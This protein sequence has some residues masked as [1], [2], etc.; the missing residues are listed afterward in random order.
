MYYGK[1]I[2]ELELPQ[3]A[4]LAGLPKAPSAFN[5]IRNPS[6]ALERRNWILGRMNALGHIDKAAYSAAVDTPISATYHGSKTA[7]DAP[8]IA[9]MVR[10][11]MLQRFNKDIYTAGY[12]V[13]T[14]INSKLQQSAE[15]SVIKGLLAYDRRHGYRGPERQIPPAN[16]SEQTDP[17]TTPIISDE[18][19]E[20]WLAALRLKKTSGGLFPAVV[21]SVTDRAFTAIFYDG[22]EITV[23]WEAGIQ[24]LRRFI[25]IDQLSPSPKAA[26]ELVSVGDIIRVV[27]TEKGLWKLSQLPAA[28]AA[29]VSLNADDG[30]ILSLVG[31]FSYQQSKFN[32]VTQATRQPGSNFKPF[33]YTAALANGFTAA[34]T[35]NDAPIVFDDAR[36]EGAW[37]PTNDSRQ[38]LWP[39][40]LALRSLQITKP[41]VHTATSFPRNS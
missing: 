30:G 10:K 24:G 39:N 20:Q 23:E 36:L 2:A 27:Q 28:Q 5:P 26:S 31:G 41:G 37:R 40:T 32:R 18:L 19:R 3:L 38:I 9:E 34:S 14:T 21:S 22:E 6:R 12:R 4:M 33:I 17:P 11:E 29:L 25:T 35:I 1:S 16:G 15:Q 13:Y 7:I 8:Y